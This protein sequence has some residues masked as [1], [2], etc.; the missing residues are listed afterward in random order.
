MPALAKS[1]RVFAPER[2]GHG[3]TADVPGLLSY[4]LM[5]EDTSAFIDAVVGEPVHVLG[6]SDGGI[7]GLMLALGRPE[8]VKRLVVMGANYDAAGTVPDGL[9]DLDADSE[10][11]SS[12][13]AMYA[14]AS[15][16]GADHWSTV[17]DKVQEMWKREPH[18]PPD[19]LTRIRARTLVLVGDDDAVTLEHTIDLYRHIPKSELAVIPGTSHALGMEKPDLVNR[20]ITDFLRLD[21][22]QTLIPIRRRST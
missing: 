9:V 4:H 15:P 7:I 22:V 14:N 6:W 2:R 5:T 20:I 12:L 3:H 17:F 21:P 19:D 10:D 13:K 8:L 11:F 16:D 1:F 18:I